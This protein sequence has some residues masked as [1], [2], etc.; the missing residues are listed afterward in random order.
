MPKLYFRDDLLKRLKDPDYAKG[1]LETALEDED[2]SH[3]HHFRS[4][5]QE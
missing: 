3:R 2:P 1:Y 4:F 5:G